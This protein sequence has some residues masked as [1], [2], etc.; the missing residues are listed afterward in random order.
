MLVSKSDKLI[1][2]A[3]ELALDGDAQALR[4]CLER[5]LPAL[6]SKDS[7]VTIP[8]LVKAQTLAEKGQ[9]VMK[10]A[11]DGDITPTEAA[12]VMQA[13]TGLVRIVE[14]DELEKRIAALEADTP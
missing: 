3:V 4:L 14:I 12:T 2:K 10:A 5:I 11:A 13:L 9:A 6:K 1:G 8:A 7:A